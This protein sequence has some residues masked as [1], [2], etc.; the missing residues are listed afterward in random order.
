MA[1]YWVHELY[2]FRKINIYKYKIICY[3]STINLLLSF[4]IPNSSPY[5]TK[6]LVE[7][8]KLSL[9]HLGR[10]GEISRRLNAIISSYRRLCKQQHVVSFRAALIVLKWSEQNYIAS[11]PLPPRRLFQRHD[12]WVGLN[13]FYLFLCWFIFLVTTVTYRKIHLIGFCVYYI[14]VLFDSSH[15]IKL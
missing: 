6:E 2:Y 11:F 15:N 4:I 12:W 13:L 14:L 5:L 3:N 1:I 7:K 10:N 8:S 9:S